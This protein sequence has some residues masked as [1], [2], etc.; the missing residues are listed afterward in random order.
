VGIAEGEEDAGE[1]EVKIGEEEVEE[2]TS[3]A[4]LTILSNGKSYDSREEE[5]EDEDEEAGWNKIPDIEIDERSKG[6][7]R[8]IMALRRKN[9]RIHRWTVQT[10]YQKQD[11]LSPR[12]QCKLM[13][14]SSMRRT[15][16]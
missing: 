12:R 1:E 3:G 8:L 15:Q 9:I 16:L 10:V 6:R 2:R 11:R 14:L 4:R 13:C 5:E 7:M